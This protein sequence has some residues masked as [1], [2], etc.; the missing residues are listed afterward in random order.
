MLKSPWLLS[1]SSL[2]EALAPSLIVSQFWE[3][4]QQRNIFFSFSGLIFCQVKPQT[5]PQLGQR[6]A[7]TQIEEGAGIPS[8]GGEITESESQNGRGWKGPLWVI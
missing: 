7:S 2:C 3:P 8:R 6:V 5:S 4:C 1:A